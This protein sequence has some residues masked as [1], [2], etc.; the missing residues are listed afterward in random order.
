MTSKKKSSFA[1]K[2]KAF[3]V[4][5]VGVIILVLGIAMWLSP[6]VNWEGFMGAWGLIGDEFLRLKDDP[7]AILGILVIIIGAAV[8]YYG[9]KFLVKNKS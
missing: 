1:S 5:L 4:L 9:I 6:E 7:F 3:V 8:S 2:L